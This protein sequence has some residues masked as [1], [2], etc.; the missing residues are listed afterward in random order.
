MYSILARTTSD[1][2]FGGLT[3]NA[4][5]PNECIKYICMRVQRRQRY[6]HRRKIRRHRAFSV[7]RARACYYVPQTKMLARP[8]YHC[9]RTHTHTYMHV[10]GRLY[11]RVCTIK[12]YTGARDV[13]GRVRDGLVGQT[14]E[15]RGG[16]VHDDGGGEK[17]GATRRVPIVMYNEGSTHA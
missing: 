1:I 9:V 14:T 12:T 13:R 5:V 16:T 2:F 4:F 10:H 11:K 8:T 15:I 6:R 3:M 17:I 7:A